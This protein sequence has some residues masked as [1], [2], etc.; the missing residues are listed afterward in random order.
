[1]QPHTSPRAVR[2]L[3]SVRNATEA[4][5][6]ATAGAHLVDAK[7]PA[8]G[9][10]GALPTSTIR[11]IVDAVGG[12][13]VTSAVAGEPETWADLAIRVRRVALTGV[14]LVKVAL[15]SREAIMPAGVSD[16]L[17]ALPCPVVAALFAED[18]LP[19][20]V[21]PE[22]AAAGFRR[23]SIGGLSPLPIAAAIRVSQALRLTLLLVGVRKRVAEV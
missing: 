5:L 12:R 10:L 8:A 17:R 9:A 22:L 7:D 3:V 11:A 20:S 19:P 21:V 6:A 2:L 18:R 1:M 4:H 13:A 14:G 23:T 16:T 15:P